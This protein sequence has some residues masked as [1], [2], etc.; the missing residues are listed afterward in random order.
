MRQKGKKRKK[1]R[2]RENKIEV[3]W[4]RASSDGME[5]VKAFISKTLFKKKIEIKRTRR[6]GRGKKKGQTKLVIHYI[7]LIQLELCPQY[8]YYQSHY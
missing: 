8:D 6:R 2:E 3:S 5:P 1:G 7:G 4:S